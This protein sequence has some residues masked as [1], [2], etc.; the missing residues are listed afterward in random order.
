MKAVIENLTD[1][2]KAQLNNLAMNF[3]A[4]HYQKIALHFQKQDFCLVLQI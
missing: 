2:T 3:H 1:T 4:T